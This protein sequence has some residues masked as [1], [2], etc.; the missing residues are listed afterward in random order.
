M[1]QVEAMQAGVPVVV[2]DLPGVRVPVM[3]TGMG[4]V[5]PPKDSTALAA[6]ITTICKDP[7]PYTKHLHMAGKQF[8]AKRSSEAF[9]RLLQ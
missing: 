3:K 8:S 5:V 1:V 7:E 6:A 4:I 9:R 2:S